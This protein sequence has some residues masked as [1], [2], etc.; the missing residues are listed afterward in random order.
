MTELEQARTRKAELYQRCKQ[1]NAAFLDAADAAERVRQRERARILKEMYREACAEV[2]RL[3]PERTQTA[4]PRGKKG[5]KPPTQMDS[6]LACGAIWADL[7]GTTWRELDGKSWSD[8]PGAATGRQMKRIQELV[9]TAMAMCT[10]LQSKYLHA[11]Y[12]EERTLE[13]IGERFGV[14]ISTVSRTLK[15]GRRRIEQYV[16]AKLLL[17]R[18]VDDRGCFDYMKFLNSAG[19][20]TERQKEMVYLIL[21]RDTS[22]RDIAGYIGR[23]P[24]TVERTAE[25]V[26][27]K[28]GGL[29][30]TVDAGWSA[31][32]VERKDWTTRSEK[33]LAED[34]GLSPAFYYR[35]VRRGERS[36]G[37]PLLYCAILN[38]LAAGHGVEQTAKALGCSAPLVKRVRRAYRDAPLPAFRED[39]RPQTPPKAKLP[40]NPFVLLGGGDA[41]IDRID[42]ATYQALQERFG[43]N[44]HAGP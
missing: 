14:D 32:R 6:V 38:R 20:L 3:D 10:P 19:I 23:T 12:V 36:G 8:L 43:G 34:L 27:D 17:G 22:Y 4:P 41:I 39:Y 30:V 25:R 9:R 24:S 2:R 44:G 28:L 7:E 40:D 16:R 21:A 29:A 5:K 42:A 35:V 13:E 18:C 33:K 1:A 11:Y 15:R 37:V 31:V 26:E